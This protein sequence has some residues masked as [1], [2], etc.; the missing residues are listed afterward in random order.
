MSLR[1]NTNK[2]GS[3]VKKYKCNTFNTIW[4]QKCISLQIG[5]SDQFLDAKGAEMSRL[6]SHDI[7]KAQMHLCKTIIDSS[8]EYAYICK[9]VKI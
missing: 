5:T 8:G 7:G 4:H 9:I 2:V 3:L 6:Q 1:S